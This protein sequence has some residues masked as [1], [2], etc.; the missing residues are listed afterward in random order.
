MTS[1]DG[2]NSFTSHVKRIRFRVSSLP[3]QTADGRLIRGMMLELCDAILLN[4][5]DEFKEDF[6]AMSQP[7]YGG[8]PIPGSSPANPIHSHDGVRM[9]NSPVQQVGDT[10]APVVMIPSGQEP[11]HQRPEIIK[12]PEGTPPDVLLTQTEVPPVQTIAAP[13]GGAVELLPTALP[14]IPPGGGTAVGESTT[15]VTKMVGPGESAVIP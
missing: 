11:V 9:I 4:A 8:G 1:V 13:N 6:V 5:G 10:Q 12:R 14:I 3:C 15:G 7:N 2:I